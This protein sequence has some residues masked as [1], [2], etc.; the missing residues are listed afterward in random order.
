M[1]LGSYRQSPFI[2]GND[3]Y[4]TETGLKTEILDYDAGKWKEAADYPFSSGDRYLRRKS[5]IIYDSKYFRICYYATASTKHSV[6]IIGGYTK[7][8]DFFSQRSSTIAE[9]SNDKWSI[10]GSLKQARSDHVAFKHGGQTM[11]VGGYSD[12]D[13]T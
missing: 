10:A 4:W 12:K 13:T 7:S 5:I 6:Y 9:Y 2:T 3:Q 11:I 1:S 8:K